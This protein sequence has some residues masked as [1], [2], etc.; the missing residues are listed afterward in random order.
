MPAP[1]L[2]ESSNLTAALTLTDL[3]H[4]HDKFGVG[5]GSEGPREVRY[6]F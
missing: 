4:L 1:D 3:S 2:T 6:C 5:S